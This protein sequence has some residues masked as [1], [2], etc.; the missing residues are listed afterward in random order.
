MPAYTDIQTFIMVLFALFAA[1]ITIDK[2]V[3]IYKKYKAPGV[4]MEEEIQQIKEHL[5]NDNK[6]INALEE[7]SKLTLRGIN[8]LIEFDI[9]GESDDKQKLEAVKDDIT[10]FLINRS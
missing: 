9:S 6:R 2:V 1:I 7:S 5:D 8:A 3:D 10:D 4:N